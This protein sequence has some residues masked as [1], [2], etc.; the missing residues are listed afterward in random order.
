MAPGAAD[1]DDEKLQIRVRELLK[2]ALEIRAVPRLVVIRRY[3]ASMPQYHIGH[4]E[5]VQRI[6]REMEKFPGLALTGN[7]YRG[8]GIPDCIHQAELAAERI[9]GTQC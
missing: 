8:I 6:E 4:L 3:P 5:R 7:G 2:K 1:Q 9:W